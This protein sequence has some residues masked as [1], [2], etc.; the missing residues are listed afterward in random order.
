MIYIFVTASQDDFDDKA[1]A[2]SFVSTTTK[3]ENQNIN[4]NSTE[5]GRKLEYIDPLESEI[6]I[7][8]R[9]K[10]PAVPLDDTLVLGKCFIGLYMYSI[11]F[12]LYLF[13]TYLIYSEP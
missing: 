2:I 8:K 3:D 10:N 5:V 12:Y 9:Q 1:S 6:V 4:L 13:I 7:G 11:K